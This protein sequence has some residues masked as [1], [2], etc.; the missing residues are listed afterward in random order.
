MLLSDVSLELDF[1]IDVEKDRFCAIAKRYFMSHGPERVKLRKALLMYLKHKSAEFI[2]ELITLAVDS[3]EEGR[4]DAA[5][6]VLNQLGTQIL[7]YANEYLVNDIK[8]WDARGRAYKP[9]D[10]YWY[11]LLRAVGQ[12]G[13][14]PD[15]RLKFVRLCI[16]A[17]E[18]GIVEAVVEALGDI[19]T[20]KSYMELDKLAKL[21]EDPFIVALCREILD[22][23]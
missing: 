5:I 16:F 6:D 17:A 21:A 18:R 7:T 4:L 12:C 13:A 11:I 19:G 14:V 1:D 9:N 3:K 20:T 22:G 15:D 8:M 23:R 2:D 10:Q